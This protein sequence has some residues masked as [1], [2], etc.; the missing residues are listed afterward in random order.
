MFSVLY[1]KYRENECGEEGQKCC[2]GQE[3]TPCNQALTCD[4][5]LHQQL[6]C[7]KLSL[8]RFCLIC[9]QIWT[10]ICI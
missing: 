1:T 4:Y 10:N 9:Q 7:I 5:N 3:S 2:S 8:L 6:V